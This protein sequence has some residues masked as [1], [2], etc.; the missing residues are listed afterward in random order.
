MSLDQIELLGTRGDIGN[1]PDGRAKM[2]VY[3]S[4][5]PDEDWREFV[6][7]DAPP[8][9][10][11]EVQVQVTADNEKSRVLLTFDPD[12]VAEALDWLKGV[13]A[14]ANERVRAVPPAKERAEPAVAAWFTER[15]GSDGL[16]AHSWQQDSADGA[17]G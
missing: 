9:E 11:A 1:A 12:R 14:A 5:K 13:V 17:P 15:F 3:L 16:A 2:M 6:N 7:S 4:A 8:S 10:V